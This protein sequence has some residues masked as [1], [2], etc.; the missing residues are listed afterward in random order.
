V[1]LV[2]VDRPVEVVDVVG[3]LVELAGRTAGAGADRAT[4]PLLAQ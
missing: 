3:E 4:T 1:E 2:G